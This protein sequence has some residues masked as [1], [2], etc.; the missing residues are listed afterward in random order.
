MGTFSRDYGQ[1]ENPQ[2][3]KFE[4]FQASW[5]STVNSH[6]GCSN[7]SQRGIRDLVA[8]KTKDKKYPHSFYS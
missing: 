5:I 8:K 3:S 7:T 4:N 6:A 2:K 1:P